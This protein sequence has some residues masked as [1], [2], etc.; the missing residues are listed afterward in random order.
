MRRFVVALA[1][2]L[3]S[4]TLWAGIL[5]FFLRFEQKR[6]GNPV[7]T[8]H[9]YIS[10]AAFQD[11]F[12][13]FLAKTL[14]IYRGNFDIIDIYRVSDDLTGKEVIIITVR[15]PGG[16]I[17]Q[18]SATPDRGGWKFDAGFPVASD[19]KRFGFDSLEL[20]EA[21]AAWLEGMGISPEQVLEYFKAHPDRFI[22]GGAIFTNEKT[23]KHCLPVD[24]FE[25]VKPAAEYTLVL[26]KEGSPSR[27]V[28]SLKNEG[29]D[30]IWKTDTAPDYA[31]QGYRAYLGGKVKGR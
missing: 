23:G 8:K 16:N 28:P 7:Y 12:L 27:L 9:V 29:Q 19:M 17:Y 2:I 25:A 11:E 24:W 15:V 26:G 20:D 31:G 18:V 14:N 4:I 21:T 13:F 1:F 6:P 22:E 30:T 3:L 5:I 10:D